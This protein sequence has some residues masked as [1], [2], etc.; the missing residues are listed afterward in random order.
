MTKDTII[1]GSQKLLY[2]MANSCTA[3]PNR[4]WGGG[5]FTRLSDIF[6]FEPILRFEIVN[7][8]LYKLKKI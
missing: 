2:V 7:F 6:L 5:S 3:R 1:V 8:Q 4:E